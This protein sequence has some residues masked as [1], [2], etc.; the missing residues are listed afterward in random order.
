[1]D[2]VVCNNTL[3]PWQIAVTV[4]VVVVGVFASEFEAPP[5]EPMEQFSNVAID[6]AA[7]VSKTTEEIVSEA[8]FTYDNFTVTTNDGYVCTVFRITVQGEVPSVL[9][10][11][12]LLQHG[13][14]DS[15]DTWV[16]AGESSLAFLLAR[17]GYDVYMANNRGNMYCKQHVTMDVASAT[18]WSF[19]WDA[20]AE[21]DVPAFVDAVLDRT[22]QPKLIYIAHSQGTTQMFAALSTQPELAF[23]IQDFIAL[24]P[25]AFVKNADSTVMRQ[26]ATFGIPN[27]ISRFGFNELMPS[28]SLLRLTLPR[29]CDNPL[30]SWLCDLSM[31]LVTG[32]SWAEINRERLPLYMAHFPCGTSVLN[33]V[34]WAQALTSQE[35]HEFRMLDYDK[36]PHPLTNE[37]VYGEKLPPMYSLASLPLNDVELTM[38]SGLEDP[39]ANPTDVQRLVDALPK[40]VVWVAL[41]KYDHMTF[42]WGQNAARDIYFPVIDHLNAKLVK[43]QEVPVAQELAQPSKSNRHF[44]F[45]V[46]SAAVAAVAL[47][48]VVAALVVHTRLKRHKRVG[49]AA[50]YYR[51]APEIKAATTTTDVV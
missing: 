29:V 41:K 33:G 17:Q 13:I 38:Y 44:V 48:A 43:T 28:N 19:S 20:M 35:S 26:I 49:N 8:G 22:K 7:D 40:K 36:L 12:V 31:S 14:L 39:L 34:H 3:L 4:V 47:V 51:H 15:S 1:M 27:I 2:A 25:V 18:F 32:F 6:K 24:A 10:P 30:T 46:G 21:Y 50:G 16:L 9:R 45:A 42:L 37:E 23:K 11:P 5:A